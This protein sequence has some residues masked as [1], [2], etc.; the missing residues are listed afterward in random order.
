MRRNHLGLLTSSNPFS[1]FLTNFV[2]VSCFS[3][4]VDGFFCQTKMREE[5]Q[6]KLKKS[7]DGG[8]Q[9]IVTKT[10]TRESTK[11]TFWL[12]IA[13]AL[14]A[15][16]MDD[17]SFHEEKDGKLSGIL[18]CN[19]RWAKKCKFTARVR[20]LKTKSE[21]TERNKMKSENWL[22]ETI[23]KDHVFIDPIGRVSL[24][25]AKNSK[26][27]CN[28][29]VNCALKKIF[30]SEVKKLTGKR[31]DPV[32]DARQMVMDDEN[33]SKDEV[34]NTFNMKN[35]KRQRRKI[36]KRLGLGQGSA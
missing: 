10:S 28:Y 8:P 25:K 19:N 11:L 26:Q 3:S 23:G 18:R 17:L 15:T 7:L 20:F 32:Q 36:E 33:W 31:D 2:L 21:L 24:Q 27:C 16:T 4:E 13:G 5:F 14:T 9:L 1:H 22:I 6:K 12:C 29:D 30:H 34:T 35:A